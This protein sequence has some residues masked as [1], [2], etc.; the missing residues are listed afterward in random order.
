MIFMKYLKLILVLFV[1]IGCSKK[2]E[3]Q[4]NELLSKSFFAEKHQ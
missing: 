2:G 3:K 4:A 1:F